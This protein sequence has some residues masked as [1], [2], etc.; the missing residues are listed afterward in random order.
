MTGMMMLDGAVDRIHKI[1]S[2]SP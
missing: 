2:Y 1:H